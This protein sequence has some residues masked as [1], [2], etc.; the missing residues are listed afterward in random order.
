MRSD[1]FIVAV[2]RLTTKHVAAGTPPVG[3][4]WKEASIAAGVTGSWKNIYT[5]DSIEMCGEVRLSEIFARFPVAVLSR[6]G[7]TC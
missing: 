5:E 2:P 6:Y 4:V 1:D 3:D 7:S